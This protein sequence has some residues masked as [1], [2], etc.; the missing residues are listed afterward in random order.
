MHFSILTPAAST[1]KSFWAGLISTIF[2]GE[3][4]YFLVKR[5]PSEEEEEQREQD[6]AIYHEPEFGTN[7]EYSNN[8]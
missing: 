6:N 3:A 1:K 8:A 4:L 7:M 2:G 5:V